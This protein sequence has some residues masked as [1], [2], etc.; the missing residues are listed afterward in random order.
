MKD[1]TAKRYKHQGVAM[2]FW[3]KG[4]INF[5]PRQLPQSSVAGW[6]RH[7]HSHLQHDTRTWLRYVRV[8][9]CYRKSVCPLLCSSRVPLCFLFFVV[10]LFLC[11][12]AC[13]SVYYFLLFINIS[14]YW[15]LF[16]LYYRWPAWWT[17]VLLVACRVN[18]FTCYLFND[19]GCVLYIFC[20]VKFKFNEI[21]MLVPV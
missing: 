9:T 10:W 6:Y 5:F 1:S 19:Y 17:F 3:G 12:C 7:I 16:W 8:D 21:S 18:F 13:L 14:F 2:I 4:V 11:V 15:I 20:E